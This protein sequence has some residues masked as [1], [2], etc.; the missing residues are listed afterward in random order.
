MKPQLLLGLNQRIKMTPQLVQSIRLLQLSAVDL[1]QELTQALD[2]NVLLEQEEAAA[3]PEA[4]N[5]TAA[6]T[7]VVTGECGWDDPVR[8]AW[9]PIMNPPSDYEPPAHW[10]EP[11]GGE[12]RGRILQQIALGISDPDDLAIALAIVD[13]VDDSGYLT[14]DLD[15]LCC[16][17]A[18]VASRADVERVLGQIQ[19][20][21]P[22]GFAARDLRECL[23]CQLD[24]LDSRLPGWTLAR[25]LVDTCLA[26]LAHGDGAELAASLEAP[27]A[28][29]TEAV[30]L[31]R[32]L[33][34]KPGAAC[35]LSAAIVPDLVVTARDHQWVVSLNP[36]ALPRLRVNASFE[37]A[38]DAEPAG[39]AQALKEQLQEARWLVRS[40]EM[41]QDTLLAVG[42]AIFSHQ[43]AFLSQG[44]EALRPLTLKQIASVAGVHESTV[45]RITTSKYVQ[46]AR[47]VYALKIFFPSQLAGAEGTHASGTA[48]KATIRRL[49]KAEPAEAPLRDVDI[50]AI[51]GRRG[52]RVA[53]RT[54]AKYREALGIP[55][56]KDRLLATQEPPLAARRSVK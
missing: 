8:D 9:A 12:P 49:I 13:A 24:D 26:L 34:P 53:R 5:Y 23:L 55:S 17:A 3:E 43:T 32:R 25:R 44:E 36:A 6:D 29:V 48:V 50:A 22:V 35:E 2:S 40:V 7:T 30:A 39:S 51:L 11:T 38:L 21:E 33:D 14:Q 42:Q 19:Q 10:A 1:E 46:T 37:R 54:V 16:D 56:S 18:V 15:S 28:A 47:G 4:A 20:M 27:I 45:S 52:I 41:R 31:I